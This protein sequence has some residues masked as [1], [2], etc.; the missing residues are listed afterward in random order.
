MNA[1]AMGKNS[2]DAAVGFRQFRRPCFKWWRDKLS[3]YF[4]IIYR[5]WCIMLPCSKLI[6][7]CQF[8]TTSQ[9]R[10]AQQLRHVCWRE[11]LVMVLKFFFKMSISTL[12]FYASYTEAQHWTLLG[13]E[14]TCMPSGLACVSCYHGFYRAKHAS[15]VLGVVILS[16]RPSVFPS[17]ECFMT[18]QETYS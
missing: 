4:I 15:A 7:K 5:Q 17:H 11:I 6:T 1:F 3:R 2:Q 16:V 12:V 8:K 10:N 9:K 18:K 14:V 13:P